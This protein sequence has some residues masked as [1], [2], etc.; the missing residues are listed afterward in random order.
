MV[1]KHVRAPSSYNYI[2]AMYDTNGCSVRTGFDTYSSI[3]Y[4]TERVGAIHT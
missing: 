1:S 2:F 4:L 3:W